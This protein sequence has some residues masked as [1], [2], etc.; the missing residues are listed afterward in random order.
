MT[1][2]D[3][4]ILAL[5]GSDMLL[6][7]GLH[8]FDFTLDDTGLLIE[9][10]DGRALR[11]WR[12]TAQQLAAARPIEGEWALE[13]EKGPHRLRCMQAFSAREDDHEQE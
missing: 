4:L 12:F 6:I 7:D 11:Q 13:G 2:A 3:S 10:V 8:A 5:Q 1:S 9:C